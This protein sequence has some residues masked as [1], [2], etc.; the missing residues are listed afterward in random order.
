MD[1]QTSSHEWGKTR[2]KPA[3][4]QARGMESTSTTMPPAQG[5]STNVNKNNNR[6]AK[7]AAAA[8]RAALSADED[9]ASAN[10]TLDNLPGSG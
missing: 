9:D 1:R 4:S 6:T 3:D 2:G 8:E 5:L 7:T 10:L